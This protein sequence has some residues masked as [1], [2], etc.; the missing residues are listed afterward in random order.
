MI[1]VKDWVTIK[2]YALQQDAAADALCSH[3]GLDYHARLARASLN[4]ERAEVIGV[5]LDNS[6]RLMF[7]DGINIADL[8]WLELSVNYKQGDKVRVKKYSSNLHSASSYPDGI[9]NRRN[10]VVVLTETRASRWYF[11]GS[12]CWINHCWIDGYADAVTQVDTPIG[13]CTCDL[14][15]G[16]SCGVFKAEMAAAG[17]VYDANLRCYVRMEK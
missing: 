16:C 2:R 11:E 10:Y 15:V 9:L 4:C 8:G 14:S 6:V 7:A 12:N 3:T 17:K 13:V 1:G 5:Y